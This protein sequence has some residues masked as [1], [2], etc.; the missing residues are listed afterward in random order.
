[1]STPI[2]TEETTIELTISE[3]HKQTLEKAAAM[4]CLSLNEYICELVLNA[5]TEQIPTPEPI[6][7]S[8]R[9]WQLFVSVL[10][11]PPEPNEVLRVAI[12]KH[13]EKYGKL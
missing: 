6:V 3:E 13:Q 1:M 2:K 11:N 10:E 7:L 4:R 12:K 8:E 5:A 9:D